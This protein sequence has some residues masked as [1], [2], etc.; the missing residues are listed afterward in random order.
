LVTPHMRG[1]D[2]WAALSVARSCG[3]SVTCGVVC[4]FSDFSFSKR[5]VGMGLGEPRKLGSKA[6]GNV[7]AAPAG[8]SRQLS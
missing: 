8:L 1:L 6:D 2:C 4:S 5:R 7:A 3:A